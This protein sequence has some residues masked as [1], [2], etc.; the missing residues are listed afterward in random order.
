MVFVG[1]VYDRRLWWEEGR[2]NL[3][4]RLG[5]PGKTVMPAIPVGVAVRTAT[6]RA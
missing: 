2:P 5:P 3:A 1:V 6:P 4:T